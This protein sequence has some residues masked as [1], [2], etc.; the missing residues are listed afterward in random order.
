M[1]PDEDLPRLPVLDVAPASS[2]TRSSTPFAGSADRADPAVVPPVEAGHGRRPPRARSPRG[3]GSR[4]PPRTRGARPRASRRPPRRTT[5]SR[6]RSESARRGW[7]SSAAYVAG[8]PCITVTPRSCRVRSA[9]SASKR[10]SRT[11]QA[12]ARTAALRPGGLAEGVGQRQPAQDDVLGRQLQQV[13]HHD[14][15]VAQQ[16]A[17]RERGAPGLT[18][19]ARRV[20]DHGRVV[21]RASARPRRGRRRR[22]PGPRAPPAR[23]T[24][25]RPRATGP[26]AD[27]PAGRRPR[28]DGAGSRVLG[29]G[30]A[31]PAPT[32]GGSSGPR[33]PRAG[34]SR[35][36]GRRTPARPA[37]RAPPGRR[38][39]ARCRRGSRPRDGSSGRPRAKVVTSSPTVSAAKRPRARAV[40]SRFSARFTQRAPVFGM[41]VGTA[42]RCVI[43]RLSSIVMAL[44]SD[45][46][47]CAPSQRGISVAVDVARI[48]PRITA[49]CEQL[50]DSVD[51]I[52]CASAASSGR[53]S[54]TTSTS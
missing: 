27:R 23:A 45:T 2:T 35:S 5:R 24:R 14:L 8:A 52:A 47:V 40:R 39:G 16:V 1:A 46:I 41:A 54:R 50:L 42:H 37:A 34:G 13:V 44:T 12:P 26:P 10:G 28:H 17:V 31:P 25:P 36:R 51:D 4:T 9:A 18:G 3:P 20:H 6:D 32:G 43:T 7:R 19:R 29:G 15:A 21:R 33:S 22:P 11:R 30:G 49:A 48:D 38:H 53:K